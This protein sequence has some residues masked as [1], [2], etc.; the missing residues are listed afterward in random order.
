MREILMLIMEF[1]GTVSFAV[2]GTLVAIS[3]GKLPPDAI[4][5]LLAS[6]D[7]T[8]AGITLPPCG[9][10]LEKVWY[11]D[12]PGLDGIGPNVRLFF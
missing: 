12:E 3:E 9:L 8:S 2:S 1:L 10:R 5:K 4:P 11:G 6:G 7:R